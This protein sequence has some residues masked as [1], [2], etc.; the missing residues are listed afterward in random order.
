VHARILTRRNVLASLAGD[1]QQR[2]NTIGAYDPG[3]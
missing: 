2:A 3:Q 1:A